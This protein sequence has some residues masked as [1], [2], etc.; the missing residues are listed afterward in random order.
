MRKLLL[1]PVPYFLLAFAP[2][3]AGQDD[4]RAVIDRAIRAHGGE[5]RLSKL[6]AVQVKNRGSIAFNVSEWDTG[7]HL[8]LKFC[9][10][11]AIQIV[12]DENEDYYRFVYR[13]PVRTLE[14]V[15]VGDVAPQVRIGRVRC[16]RQVEQME[17]AARR[18]REIR[19][20]G[21]H[22]AARRAGHQEGGVRPE[23]Q[24]AGTV[25]F[26]WTQGIGRT[27]WAAATLGLLGAR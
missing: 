18:G 27:R 10:F 3:A 4:A 16:R 21:R 22:D 14:P 1:L 23:C 12:P 5:E 6:Q 20:D 25:R 13:L 2:Q 26:A 9:G 11:R 19:G 17:R 7:T 15:P 24:P 8:W